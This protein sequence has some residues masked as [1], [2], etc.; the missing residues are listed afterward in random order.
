MIYST[1]NELQVFFTSNFTSSDDEKTAQQ[2]QSSRDV[3]FYATYAVTPQG[4]EML[5]TKDFILI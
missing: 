1:G 4:I 5:I 3:G 2:A